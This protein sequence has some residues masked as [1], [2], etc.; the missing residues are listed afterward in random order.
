M[1]KTKVASLLA[2]FLIGSSLALTGASAIAKNNTKD[3]ETQLNSLRTAQIE[4]NTQNVELREEMDNQNA[5]ITEL[6]KALDS[7]NAKVVEFQTKLDKL[8]TPQDF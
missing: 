8:G 2:A 7:S 1:L 3:L 5:T 6:K 4:Q